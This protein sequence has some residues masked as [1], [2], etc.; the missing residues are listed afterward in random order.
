M[1]KKRILVLF[2]SLV[3]L[4]SLLSGCS[5]TQTTAASTQTTEGDSYKEVT[6]T[7]GD[8]KENLSLSGSL[9]TK[10]KDTITSTTSSTV[11]KIYVSQN[12]YVS[13]DDYLVLMENGRLIKAPYDGMITQIDVSVGDDVTTQTELM[14]IVDNSE[15]YIES[16]IDESDIS[17]VKVGQDVDVT[18]FALDKEYSGKI[19]FISSEATVSGDRAAFEIKIT[20]EGDCSD[21]YY[22]LS[23]EAD[24]ILNSASDA[25]LLP[26]DAV[27]VSGGKKTV[28]VKS[29]DTYVEKEVTLGVQDSSNVQVLSG[30]EENDVVKVETKQSSQRQ[31]S[32]GGFD[33]SSMPGGGNMSQRDFQGQASGKQ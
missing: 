14:N 32:M 27:T 16:S 10:D 9:V 25:L 2:S 26:I 15:Y 17:K 5:L 29:G 7:T 20:L 6:V 24:I 4:T 23:A 13:E 12:D 22:G 33:S 30:L 21:L 28:M 11:E 19:T 18:V 31:N 8:I 3:I 1:F